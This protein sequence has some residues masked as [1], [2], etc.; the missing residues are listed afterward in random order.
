LTLAAIILGFTALK[1]FRKFRDT[2]EKELAKAEADALALVDPT[3]PLIQMSPSKEAA[4]L[5]SISGGE[6]TLPEDEASSPL[7]ESAPPPSPSATTTARRRAKGDHAADPAAEESHTAASTTTLATAED[8]NQTARIVE[9]LIRDARQFPTEK[10]LALLVLWIGLI[11]ITF[12]KGG[13]GVDS[14][15]GITCHSPWYGVLIGIQF[16]WTL[17]FAAVFGWKLMKDTE[18][19]TSVGYPF[20]S[21]DVLWDFGKVKFYAAFTFVAGIVAGLIGIGGGMVLG[22]L[23]VSM[24]YL[25]L[26]V[27][28]CC[29]AT[30]NL[31]SSHQPCMLYITFQIIHS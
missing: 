3:E 24:K 28:I 7:E 30:E 1:T 15:V 10:L 22:P 20:H 23:M 4:A 2:R 25:T 9:L 13:K 8:H 6:T 11:L 19:K 18:E 26:R 21:Q 12:L 14:L 5:P 31:L 16:L 29:R 27:F 17:G